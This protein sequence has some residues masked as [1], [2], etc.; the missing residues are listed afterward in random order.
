MFL[1]VGAL[2]GHRIQ[3]LRA[4]QVHDWMVQSNA[5]RAQLN[6]IDVRTV[7]LGRYMT[8][9][10][11][12]SDD[13]LM[14]L[15]GLAPLQNEMMALV[16]AKS[17]LHK[18]AFA[19][20][21]DERDMASVRAMI[22]RASWNRRDT[23]KALYAWAASRAGQTADA[24]LAVLDKA[25]VD[26]DLDALLAKAVLL[27]V[28]NQH[29]DAHRFLR[30]ARIELANLASGEGVR[31]DVRS[32]SYAVALMGY[33][34]FSKTG[35]AVYRDEALKVAHAYQRA[36]PFLAWPYGLAAL[37]SPAGAARTTAACRA[38]YLDKDS[39]F[40]KMSGLKPSTAALPC[41]KPIW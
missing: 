23:L 21:V 10:R 29:A 15:G 17:H 32:A 22:H 20:R 2:A 31:D 16:L 25:T 12:P 26:D 18:V 40:L 11:V 39:Q 33:L 5:G 34:L 14:L 30:A 4:R 41:P 24:S 19:E 6:G 9:D 7:Y 38:H 36:D 13:D 27:G 37:L 1:W 35:N 8:E 3:G 28:N